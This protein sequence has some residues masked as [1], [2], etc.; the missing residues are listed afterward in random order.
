MPSR[1]PVKAFHRKARRHEGNQGRLAATCHC[2]LCPARAWALRQLFA[3]PATSEDGPRARSPDCLTSD[4]HSPKRKASSRTGGGC[5]R[6]VGTP[7]FSLWRRRLV[8]QAAEFRQAGRAAQAGIDGLQLV[9]VGDLGDGR[10]QGQT[11][12]A[13]FEVQAEFDGGQ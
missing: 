3:L 10:E 9:E 11:V 7:E 2:S 5:D 8:T 4:S 12:G 13:E 6:P 1:L